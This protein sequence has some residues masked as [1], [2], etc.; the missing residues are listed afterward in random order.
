MKGESQD[1]AELLEYLHGCHPDESAL[2]ARLATDS[3]LRAALER[4]RA[5]ADILYD[6]ARDEAPVLDLETLAEAAPRSRRRTPLRVLFG[7]PL[8]CAASILFVTL[9]AAPWIDT[10]LAER[11]ATSAEQAAWSMRVSTPHGSPPGTPVTV[12][13]QAESLSGDPEVVEI[14]WIPDGGTPE[15]IRGSEFAIPV[16][17]ALAS[18]REIDILA[19]SDDV[20]R[21]LTVPLGVATDTPLAHLSSDKPI[22]RPGETAWMRAVV[23]DR[24]SL[25]PA[26]GR[27]RLRVV[28][29]KGAPAKRF[30]DEAT[31]GVVP[32][33][34]QV[35]HDAAGGE[36]A[37]ELRD[38][39]NE[40]AI[41]RL[42]FL[43]Q[44]FQ[45]PKLEKEL[46]LGR[47]SYASG[48]EGAAAL[49]VASLTGGSTAGAAVRASVF[50]DGVAVDEAR[51]T[52]DERGRGTFT[53]E[54][55]EGIDGGAGR[56]ACRIVVGGIIE[57]VVASFTVPT[58]RVDVQVYPEGGALVPGFE[59]RVYVETTDAMGRPVQV[60]GAVVNDSGARIV[61]FA[62]GHQGRG[63][64]AFTPGHGTS[65]ELIL[66]DLAASS[67]VSLQVDSKYV[68]G[69]RSLEDSYPSGAPI[70]LEVTAPGDEEWT[71]A[72]FCR[73]VLVGRAPVVGGGTHTVALDI[74]DRIAGVLR[75]TLFDASLDPVAER[76]IHRSTDRR[77]EVEVIPSNDRPLPGEHQTIDLV[78]RDERGRPA[79]C[80]LGL[81]VVDAA[82]RAAAGGE[83]LSLARQA[84]LFGDVEDLEN[85]P[86]FALDGDDAAH[87][88][89]LLLGTRGW[90]RF[91]WVDPLATVSEFG[92]AGKRLLVREGNSVRPRV[93]IAGADA[94]RAAQLARSDARRRRSRASFM[95]VTAAAISVL[96]LL[97]TAIALGLRRHIG[98]SAYLV[99]PIAAIGL[100]V[101]AWHF[102]FDDWVEFAADGATL[103]AGIESESAMFEGKDIELEDV[104]FDAGLTD[105][106][107]AAPLAGLERTTGPRRIRIYAHR[108][109]S[110]LDVR[111]DFTETLYWNPLLVTDDTGRAQIS[112]DLS[113]R[114]TRFDVTV[115]AHGAG[116][117]GSEHSS[118]VSVPPLASE[119]KLPIELS[120]GDVIS[121]PVAIEAQDGTLAEVGFDV[122]TSGPLAVIEE[123]GPEISLADGRGRVLVEL[124]A[125]GTF[126]DEIGSL[127]FTVTG[128]GWT[129]TIRQE[130]RVVPRGFP[131][132]V[133]RSGLITGSHETT[134][135]M[136]ADYVP[137]TLFG[138]LSAYPSPLTEVLAGL[139]G[140][141]R[142]PH[143]CFEQ[144]SSV[145]YPNV[146]AL[147]LMEATGREDPA[148]A[149]RAHDLLKDGYARLVSF[150]CD[151]GGFEWFG[152]NPAHESLTAYGLLQF[153]D[154]AQV[155][156]VEPELIQR[157]REWLLS[158]R[159]GEGGFE[160]ADGGRARFGGTSDDVTSAY[161]TYSLALTG[162]PPRDL[163]GEL[164]RLESRALESE[165]A[166]EVAL[167]TS[168]LHATG[169]SAAARAARVRLATMQDL[170]GSLV[171][172][173]ASI[174]GSGGDD[175]R[176]ET[177]ALAVSAWLDDPDF[178]AR[179]RA[180]LHWLVQQR[181]RGRFGATQA[182]VQALRALVAYSIHDGAKDRNGE[183]GVFIG[184]DEVARVP[185][186]T[187]NHEALVVEG[188]AHHLG[189]GTNLVRLEASGGAS[190]PFALDLEY[191]SDQPADEADCPLAL[192]AVLARNEVQEGEIAVIEIAVRNESPIDQS[193]T[194][195]A[196][197]LPAGLECPTRV[198]EDLAR[199]GSFDFWEMR[200]RDVYFYWRGLAPEAACEFTLECVAR[201][202]G[203]TTGPASRV[204][205]YY[206]PESMRWAEPMTAYVTEAQ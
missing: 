65:Y 76:L 131:H 130:V 192:T 51:F 11:R 140:M 5:D 110:R 95:T 129:D 189:K 43:V 157:T 161:V 127:E 163:E 180:A 79:R 121:I 40:F 30:T 204:Y 8:R 103:R 167:A 169:R 96:S 123:P 132:H 26:E 72:A 18:H 77:I 7:T 193:M 164:D 83:R 185:Y 126:D 92:P 168:A 55:P 94:Q 35:P 182:T 21:K 91:A 144:T 63:R 4:V 81:G 203:T 198:L 58:D 64:F 90:R 99:S 149:R 109:T 29:P 173:T 49:R 112:F 175:L 66:D 98:F 68:A 25:N 197:G 201:V 166:Y 67:A 44:R 41:E 39:R 28:D 190:I 108:N 206:E 119:A 88:I 160:R 87:R 153:H 97:A 10:A 56:V 73:G 113:D 101:A 85:A 89:D 86:P 1:D 176:V 54:V 60:T 50:V 124:E 152:A 115:D 196:V 106:G 125:M 133:A 82:V 17:A 13:V 14:Q 9:L 45:P 105:Q 59:S 27:Y 150:E 24:L 200:G 142:E 183:I 146:L 69:I 46:I 102:M 52:L 138:T 33:S 159:D 80:V 181:G 188:L 100:L 117:I 170:D 179:A 187:A 136:P 116:R 22:Y 71:L 154:M 84:M 38:S 184:G 48:S 16:A 172:G 148:T 37:L 139:D 36:Y 3:E 202:P 177:T 162:T 62:T 78:A 186:S 135:S 104:Q 111:D 34:W 191:V 143:G 156:D 93:Q 32:I 151:G 19:R 128:G 118:F 23:L 47:E 20:E 205:R 53:F 155:Y 74:P 57:T 2:E 12:A 42:T 70:S 147:T 199:G 31:N 141:L 120:A 61:D 145:N 107:N 165:D 134:L 114:A 178:E 75:V 158:R 137:G 15:V 195:A 194:I 171:G 122:Q 174:T 6:A